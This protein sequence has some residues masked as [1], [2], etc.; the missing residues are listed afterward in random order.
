MFLIFFVLFR[1][2]FFVRALF[3]PNA[4]VVD[5]GRPSDTLVKVRAPSVPSGAR[6][7]PSKLFFGGS[8]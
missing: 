7:K 1:T 6:G 3:W 2:Y 8:E 4:K 5:T